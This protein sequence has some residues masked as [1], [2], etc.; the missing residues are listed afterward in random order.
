MTAPDSD[1]EL[2]DDVT[3]AQDELRRLAHQPPSSPSDLSPWDFLR[4]LPRQRQLS[5]VWPAVKVLAADG[6]PE[7]RALAL[8]MI[9]D[10]R[11]P[12]P[13]VARALVDRLLELAT[14]ERARFKTVALAQRLQH[15][16]ANRVAG[17]TRESEITGHILDV[18]ANVGYVF[19]DSAGAVLGK[20]APDALAPIATRTNSASPRFWT[21]A[22][23]SV[24]VYHRDR[25]LGFL[26]A[27]RGLP[28]SS[29]EE[30]CAQVLDDLALPAENVVALVRAAGFATATSQ[31]Q[32]ASECRRAL[33]IA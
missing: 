16:L 28:A 26:Q 18:A 11:D 31:P 14:S 17:S 7:V 8:D 20:W 4:R 5:V 22:A 21:N 19:D 9:M 30:I 10:L 32:S 27:L 29:R 1:F 25:L 2:S 3:A 6:D 12:P 15:A 13:D 24:A 23:S 33:G